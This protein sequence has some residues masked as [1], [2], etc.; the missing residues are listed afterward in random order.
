[1][2]VAF[3]APMKPPDH[4][5]PSGDRRMARLLMAAL[6]AGGHDVVLAGRLRS[7]DDATVPGRQARIRRLGERLA[8]RLVRRWQG[9]P[10]RPELWFTYHLYH[11]APDWLGP[12]VADA[13]GIPYVVAEASYAPKRRHGPWADGFA[14][15][16][17]ALARADAVLAVS[18][19][20]A[21]GLEAVVPP[22]RLHRL[23]PFIETAPF[24][25][26]ITRRG[27]ARARLW[28]GDP[29]PWLLAVAMMRPGDKAQSY[30]VLAEALGR[31]A[32]RPWRLALVGDGPL[33]DGI[34]SR[35][36]PGR[37]YDLGRQ[38]LEALPEIDAA[39]DLYVWPAINEAYGLALLEAQAAGLP[40]VAGR[41]GGVPDIVRDGTTGLLTP[42]GDA[43]AFAGAVAALLD[44]P[45]RRTAMGAAAAFG[46]RYAIRPWCAVVHVDD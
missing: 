36:P 19:V 27:A 37:V 12:A 35:F 30:A 20:D 15:A 8:A 31:L 42:P 45:A 13:L 38:P 1:M 21:A 17:A 6:A 22:G 11:K 3:Y 46:E 2:R 44:G 34:V 33:R 32:G 18:A 39:A 4:P 14:G 28:R 40:V 23:P 25:A 5:V 43:A 10:D 16:A 9:A 24:A 29:G 7:W 26:A 41:T